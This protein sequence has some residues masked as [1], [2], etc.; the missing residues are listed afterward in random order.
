MKWLINS[1]EMKYLFFV[2]MLVA[3]LNTFAQSDSIPYKEYKSY[4][5]LTWNDFLERPESEYTS[6]FAASVS[7]GLDLK[8]DYNIDNVKQNFSFDVKACLYPSS[9][10]VF[11]H[12]KDSALL[13][14]EQLHYDITELHARKL[15]KLIAEYKLGRNIRKDLKVIYQGVEDARNIMQNNYDKE[16]IHSKDTAQQRLWNLKIDTLL[17]VYKAHK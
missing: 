11:E 2:I 10:W 9:S 5:K 16:T 13:A 4:P 15:R 14:H 12:K 3:N 7:T 17:F 1:I 6:K 8:W